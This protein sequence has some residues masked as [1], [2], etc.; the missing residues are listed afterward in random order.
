MSIHFTHDWKFV[1]YAQLIQTGRLLM[2]L[3]FSTVLAF[4]LYEDTGGG[5][6]APHQDLIYTDGVSRFL[7][8]SL[9]L[10]LLCKPGCFQL[11]TRLQKGVG[12]IC[13]K[14]YRLPT[15]DLHVYLVVS[16]VFS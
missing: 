3:P 6:A 15:G 11:G 9:I 8:G 12:L 2:L 10:L 5:R 16:T 13:L 14:H 1:L 7:H 4:T